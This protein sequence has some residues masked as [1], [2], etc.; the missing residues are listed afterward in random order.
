MRILLIEDDKKIAAAI[1]KSLKA[2]GYAVDVA[3]DGIK[4]EELAL[5][6]DNDLIILDVLL[7]LQ[8]GWTTCAN[9]RK[10]KVMTPIIMLTAL[11][12]VNDKIRGLDCGADDYLAKPFHFGELLARI[13]S[14]VRRKSE[15]RS[16]VIEKF[17][18]SLDVNTHKAFRDGLEISLTSKEY[19]LLELFMMNPGRILSRETISEH[20]WDMNFEPR[21]NVIESFVKF[22]RQKVDK[23]FKTPL[24]RTVRGSGYIFSDTEP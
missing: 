3:Y 18:L 22:L 15:V 2:E 9:L 12:D 11:Q 6:S 4:G 1:S 23:G 17:G 24:I 14:L 7:P 8:D 19:A 20:V 10:Q 5:V 13:R 16:T 21:S